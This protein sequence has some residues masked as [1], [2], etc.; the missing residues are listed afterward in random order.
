MKNYF[1]EIC[2]KLKKNFELA[3]SILL[4]ISKA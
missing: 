1:E 4:I 3:K 2:E